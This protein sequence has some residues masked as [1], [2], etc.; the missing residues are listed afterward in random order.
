[1][2]IFNYLSSYLAYS[3]MYRI[4]WQPSMALSMVYLHRLPINKENMKKNFKFLN[5][6]W[7][8]IALISFQYS[9]IINSIEIIENVFKSRVSHLPWNAI[10]QKNGL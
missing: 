1:M 8:S 5:P 6:L 7:F 9:I 2:L 3:K 10:I 4:S